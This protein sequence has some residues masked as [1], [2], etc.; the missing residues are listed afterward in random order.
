M[1]V[2]CPNHFSA[3]TTR[4]NE[5]LYWRKGN[6]LS[7]KAKIG[8]VMATMNKEKHR[9]YIIHIPHWLWRFVPPCFITPQNILKK[10]RKKDRQIFDASRKY[11]WDSTPVNVMTSTP[12][13]S[14]LKC[15]FGKVQEDVLIWAYNLRISYPNED[16]IVHA[17]DIKSCF[18]QTKH[19]PDIMGAFSYIL[20]EYPFFQIGLAFGADFSPAN[21]EA[22][23]RIQCALA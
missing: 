21:W 5:L 9:N 6:H 16:I 7:I 20:A 8:Q 10:P 17:N 1:T 22:V 12:L 3:S 23:R 11:D 2:G 19:H 18:C 15:E 13:G 14:K 4:D